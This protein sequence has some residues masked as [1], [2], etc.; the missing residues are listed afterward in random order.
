MAK[1]NVGYIFKVKNTDPQE[2]A[3]ALRAKQDKQFSSKGKLLVQIYKDEELT[4]PKHEKPVLKSVE[5][6]DFIGFQD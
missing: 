3:V 1:E 4:Q 2:Y 5:L 6:L